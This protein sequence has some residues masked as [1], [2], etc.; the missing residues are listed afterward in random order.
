MTIQDTMDRWAPM[1]RILNDAVAAHAFP[2]AVVAIGRRDTVL[3]LQA[4]GNLDY[5]HHQPVTTR[6]VYDIASLTKVVGLT[7]AMMQL[8]EAGRVE[9]DA[10]ARR[11][12][13]A[14]HDSTITVRQLL[15]HSSGLPAFKQWWPRVHSRADMLAL[16]NS[17]PLEQ[18]PGTKMVYSD[19]GAMVMMEIVEAVTG[20]R[21]DRYLKSH[22]FDPLGMRDTRYRPPKSWLARI[23]PTELDT[24]YRHTMVRGVV[25]DENAYSMGGISGHAGLFS[26]A[27]DLVKFAQ[28]MLGAWDRGTGAPGHR[29]VNP[30]IVQTFTQ[31]QRPGFSSRALGWD[32]PSGTSS[33]GSHLSAQAFGHTGFTGTSIWMDPTQ[34]LFVILLTNRVHP[35][36]ENTRILAVRRA[37]AD[38][39]VE[40]TRR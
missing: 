1:A 34:D 28:M 21:I 9:L 19:I 5:E 27:P 22:L 33:A 40:A 3:Y 12:V 31:V 18:P 16:V 14:F 38:A 4:F 25:H 10:P 36:R 23:A 7:T 6:T 11:Y 37:V 35:T 24:A 2:G 32:T 20:E 29:V 15:T 17:E 39:A 8:V 26:T 30:E 13:P